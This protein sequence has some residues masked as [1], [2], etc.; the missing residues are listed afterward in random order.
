MSSQ[1]NQNLE[2]EKRPTLSKE[3]KTELIDLL[4]SGLGTSNQPETTSFS[5]FKDKTFTRDIYDW[6]SPYC[7]SNYKSSLGLTKRW[8]AHYILR[9]QN[10]RKKIL[11]QRE[12]GPIPSNTKTDEEIRDTTQKLS[13]TKI[14][15]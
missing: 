15:Q 4:T 8:S 3:T 7:I 1:E 14:T 9:E 12:Q 5:T 11:Q 13:E 6:R 2:K 10:K